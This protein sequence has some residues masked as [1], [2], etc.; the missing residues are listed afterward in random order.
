M[1][2]VFLYKGMEITIHNQEP[3]KI[4]EWSLNLDH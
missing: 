1:L 4:T 3:L 2:T